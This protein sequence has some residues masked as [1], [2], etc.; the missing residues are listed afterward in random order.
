LSL[1]FV[2]HTLL[3]SA[4]SDDQVSAVATDLEGGIDQCQLV[5]EAYRIDCLRYAVGDATDAT[6][7]DNTAKRANKALQTLESQLKKIVRKNRD[8]QA[9]KI[10]FNGNQLTAVSAPT[11]G[12]AQASAQQALAQTQTML[13][14]ANPKAPLRFV[15][16]SDA[17]DSGKVLLRSA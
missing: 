12:A 2:P 14:K 8:K 1:T 9:P 13:L 10:S 3:A 6:A 11:L 4:L 17:L 5:A 16:I 7:K 15:R